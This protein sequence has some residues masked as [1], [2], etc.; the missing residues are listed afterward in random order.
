MKESYS[1]FVDFWTM[2]VFLYELATSQTPFR[3]QDIL[4][5]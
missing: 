1:K 5:K 4:I 2:G 3:Q